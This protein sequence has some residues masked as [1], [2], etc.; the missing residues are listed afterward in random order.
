MRPLPG[1]RR[2]H[3]QQQER[4]PG[5]PGARPDPGRA[6][7]RG[8]SSI[9]KAWWGPGP[10]RAGRA[11]VVHG[12]GVTRNP[13][14]ELTLRGPADCGHAWLDCLRTVPPRFPRPL[15]PVDLGFEDAREAI[16]M[17]DTFSFHR[18]PLFCSLR[19][20]N[21]KGGVSPW[22][23]Q[24]SPRAPRGRSKPR[25][26]KARTSEAWSAHVMERGS[27]VTRRAP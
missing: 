25:S 2:R 4:R 20:S 22:S 21:R 23:R 6:G 12:A 3:S 10:G 15:F 14:V 11:R 24:P 9:A 5:G 27:A 19:P 26:A 18:F 17:Q 13:L 7:N 16:V 8:L 1:G